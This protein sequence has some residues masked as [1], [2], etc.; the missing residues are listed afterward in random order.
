MKEEDG[1]YTL[2]GYQLNSTHKITTA[3]EDYLEMIYRLLNNKSFARINELAEQL[4]VRPSS[5]SK[6][7]NNLKTAGYLI[8]EKYGYISLTDKG[9]EEGKYLLFRHE[10][11]HQFLCLI[12]D[13]SNE[14]E[15]V[16]K[17]EH[18]INQETVYNIERIK[19]KLTQ[20]KIDNVNC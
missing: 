17:I 11:L 13:S 20:L 19:S 1:F 4:H 5:A 2:K 10:T 8:F 3:M 7:V 6:M 14:L 16:E 15:Q 12:N 9:R 18:F